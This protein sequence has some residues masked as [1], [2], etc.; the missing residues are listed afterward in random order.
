MPDVTPYRAL[1][2][3]GPLFPRIAK[4]DEGVFFGPFYMMRRSAIGDHRFPEGV[5]HC[6]DLIFFTELAHDRD[7]RAAAKLLQL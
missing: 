2:D 3:T 5:T 4:F 1:T 6:E 7:L